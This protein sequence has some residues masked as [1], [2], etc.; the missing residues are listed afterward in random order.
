[1]IGFISSF[2][3]CILYFMPMGLCSRIVTGLLDI[4]IVY[5]K[6]IMHTCPLE[7]IELWLDILIHIYIY[8]YISSNLILLVYSCYHHGTSRPVP[9]AQVNHCRKCSTGRN[10]KFPLAMRWSDI[11]TQTSTN[12]RTVRTVRG[13]VNDDFSQKTK[14]VDMSYDV[15]L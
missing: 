7:I 9:I 5:A 4:G 3:S 8:I 10:D 11:L 14:S 13:S 2:Y 12:C 1:M 6:I 15:M